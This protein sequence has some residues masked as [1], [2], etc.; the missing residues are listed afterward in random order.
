MSVM[1]GTQAV[2]KTSGG[3]SDSQRCLVPDF[4]HLVHPSRARTRDRCAD[5]QKESLT[6]HSTGPSVSPRRRCAKEAIVIALHQINRGACA[7]RGHF[8][9]SGIFVAAGAAGGGGGGGRRG[10]GGGARTPAMIGASVGT[11]P[12]ARARRGR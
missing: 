12:N 1:R 5:T 3:G 7:A 2:A 11:R 9:V 4:H 10:G 6:T 8:M